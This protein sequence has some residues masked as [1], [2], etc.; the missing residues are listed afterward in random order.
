MKFKKYLSEKYLGSGM[1]GSIGKNFGGYTEVFVNP[2]KSEMNN[3]GGKQLRFFADTKKKKLYVFK[4]ECYHMDAWEEII[5]KETGDRRDYNDITLLFGVIEKIK[6]KWHMITSDECEADEW[7][8]EDIK[9]AEKYIDFSPWYSVDESVNITS[10]IKIKCDMDGVLC[11]FIG[12]IQ[13]HI[14]PTI[15]KW[16]IWKVKKS[17]LWNKVTEI[18]E[19]FWSSLEWLDDG[20]KLWNY[21]KKYN[22]GILTAHPEDVGGSIKGKKKWIRK[23]LGPLYEKTAIIT[24]GIKKQ[25]YAEKNVILIDDN[26]RNISQWKSKGGIGIL[27]KNSMDTINQLKGIKI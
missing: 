13:K 18:G 14:D 15:T 20:K 5:Q 19:N 1:I 3:I 2:T 24:L 21:I 10:N 11:N 12:G 6:G 9:W 26:A 27:H 4:L 7:E 25:D 8:P 17:G 22:T 23:N 16:D